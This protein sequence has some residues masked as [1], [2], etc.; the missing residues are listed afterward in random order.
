MQTSHSN[1]LLQLAD[2]VAGA[3]QGSLSEKTDRQV[4]RRLLAAKEMS[5]QMWPR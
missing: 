2:M 3:I 5:V 1:H 4:Y